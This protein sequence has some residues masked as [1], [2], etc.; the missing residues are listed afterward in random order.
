VI[1][2]SVRAADD[3][4]PDVTAVPVLPPS[5]LPAAD[6]LALLRLARSA[7]AHHLGAPLSGTVPPMSRALLQR[8]DHVFVAFWVGGSMR[9]CRGTAAR[10]LHQNVLEATRKALNDERVERFA[11]ADLDRLRIE[12]DVIGTPAPFQACT[13]E[14]FEEA[15][16]LGIHGILAEEAGRQAIFCSSVAITRNW[17]IEELLRRLCEKGGW[18]PDAYL[19]GGLQFSRFRSIAFIE[20]RDGERAQELLRGHRPIGPADWSRERISG[21]IGDAADYLLRTQRPDGGFVYEYDASKDEYSPADH[22]VRQL[23]TTW[24]VAQLSHRDG[25]PRCRHA[26]DR[27]LAYVFAR[28]RWTSTDGGRLIV[29]DEA[30]IASLGAIAFAL[31]T[32][33]ATEDDRFKDVARDLAE[34]ILSLQR[35]DG[36]FDT[37][38]PAARRPEDENFFPGEAML[39]L[40][41]LHARYPDPRYPEALQRALPYYRAHFRR[42]LSSAFIPWQ[43]AAYAHL[44][45]FTGAREY[46]DFVFELADAI[47]PLQ[48]VGADIPYPD[49]AGGYRT[50]GFPG[51]SS[52]TH[53][54]GVLEAY[55]LALRTGDRD[56]AARYQRA[57]LLAALFT[58]RLQ[59]TDE[60]CYYIRRPDRAL[61]AFRESLADGRLRIDHTQ[62][63]LNSLLKVERHLFRAVADVRS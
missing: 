31:L 28:T 30:E 35:S 46:S 6:Q 24:I 8:T 43:T 34:T 42:Q 36:G 60:N 22:I 53:N 13:L 62:H 21:A 44:F 10:A 49:Y 23:A 45:R 16:E 18:A 20:S 14:Q 15:I 7:A 51:I 54:E 47:L 9:G 4:S 3:G 41:H 2:P 25:M 26:L 59:L 63:A 1:T 32:L 38:F 48:H 27:A 55:D 39:A 61:G 58:L 52:A 11:P 12:I 5:A 40:M 29:S 56:R 37:Q 19:R 17:R 33:V 57:G 50:R